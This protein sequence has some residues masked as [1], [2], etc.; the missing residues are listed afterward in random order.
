MI[1]SLGQHTVYEYLYFIINVENYRYLSVSWFMVS[2]EPGEP[3]VQTITS[4]CT[5]RL[6]VPT[7]YFLL[8]FSNPQHRYEVPV[9]VNRVVDPDWFNPDPDWFNPDPDPAI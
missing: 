3:L 2:S 5:G 7:T 1:G 8:Q 4:C 9:P 6:H